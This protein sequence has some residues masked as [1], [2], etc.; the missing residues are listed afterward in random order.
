MS[1]AMAHPGDRERSRLA[2]LQDIVS[3]GGQALL[4]GAQTIAEG[5][6]RRLSDVG[7]D[8]S[9]ILES[10]LREALDDFIAR[11][12]LSIR[13][14]IEKLADRVASLEQTL[15]GLPA[16]PLAEVVNTAESLAQQAIESAAASNMHFEELSRH[17][18]ALEQRLGE[19]GHPAAAVEKFG[20]HLEELREQVVELGKEVGTRVSEI[21]ALDDRLHRLERRV[22]EQARG[23]EACSEDL[24][25]I[26]ERLSRL[27]GRLSDLSREQIAR[28][29]EAAAVRERLL[30]LEQRFRVS[31][32]SP[33]GTP[34]T[35]HDE[36]GR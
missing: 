15:A 10:S 5:L 7:R 12:A 11:L 3:G 9:S 18:Q 20:T 19:G 28:T 6:Q 29:V 26:R 24:A 31:E 17:L 4:G 23:Q 25:S 2:A 34:E 36:D 32:A 33:A 14:E 30:R 22:A 8:V 16:G 35:A 27:E 13:R 1:G 21:G